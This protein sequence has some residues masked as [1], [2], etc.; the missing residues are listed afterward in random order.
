MQPANESESMQRTA[1]L[2]EF[3]Q[4]NF[5]AGGGPLT[6]VFSQRLGALLAYLGQRLRLSPNGLTALGLSCYVTAAA[7]Y[8]FLPGD[9]GALLICL[10]FYQLAYGLDCSD[11]QL[12]RAQGRTSE[13]GAWWDVSADAISSLCLAFA[14]IYWLGQGADGLEPWVLLVVLPLAVGRVLT[15]YSSKAAASS[16]GTGGGSRGAAF[17][18]TGKWLLWL[19]IDTPTLLLVVCLLR[20]SVALLSLYVAGMGIVYCLNAAYLGLTKLQ[21]A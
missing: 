18:Q 15:L 6:Q 3:W 19:I 20:D 1:G 5:S 9:I 2:G 7:L 11:G 12:A 16:R 21:R 17:R 8:A 13:F 10:V 4:L 14:L